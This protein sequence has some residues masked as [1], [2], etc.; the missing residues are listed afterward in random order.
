MRFYSK[1]SVWPAIFWLALPI[2]WLPTSTAAK[3]TV[4]LLVKPFIENNTI[5]LGGA[6]TQVT[7]TARVNLEGVAYHWTLSGPGTY[8]VDATSRKFYYTLPEHLS[9]A[10]AE[11]TIAVAVSEE[12]GETATEQ[13]TFS[14]HDPSPL[15]TAIPTPVP[16]QEGMT[17]PTPTA[18]LPPPKDLAQ[19]LEEAEAYFKRTFYTEPEGR[20]ALSLYQEVL[21]L[22]PGNQEARQKIREMAANLKQWAEKASNEADYGKAQR[23]LQRYGLIAQYLLTVPGEQGVKE[24]AEA[25][26]QRLKEL[27]SLVEEPTFSPTPTATPPPTPTVSQADSGSLETPPPTPQEMTPTPAP[28]GPANVLKRPGEAYAVIIGLGTYADA[29]IPPLRFTEND[30]QGL[31]DVLTDPRYGGIPQDHVKLLLDQAATEQAMKHAIGQ[32]L[33]QQA[34]EKDLVLLYFA[35]HT[36]DEDGDSFWV[37][38][39]AESDDFYATALNRADLADLFARIPAK[40]ILTFVDA[41][42]PAAGENAK[43]KTPPPSWGETLAGEGRITISAADG[44]Q[45]SLELAPQQHGLFAYYL[46]EGLKGEADANQDGLIDLTEL[47]NYL[48][49]QA[50]AASSKSG[51]PQTPQLQG[52]LSAIPLTA[53]PVILQKQQEEKQSQAKQ[54]RLIEIYR[55]GG[56]SAE[57]FTKAMAILKNKGRDQLLEDLLA[58]KLSLELFKESF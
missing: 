26:R 35:G 37:P 50:A 39:D 11:V 52:A 47:W 34:Q 20:N 4:Q 24:E 30:A 22:E 5:R 58:G 51:D 29:R 19:L 44:Q 16:S 2:L 15:P 36:A 1:R 41:S 7:I 3:P 21:R 32:W 13:V 38:H 17:T 46:L 42:Y 45:H 54:A 33:R 8:T 31:A 28:V 12:Q 9:A 53:N 43:E 23:Y 10:R 18:V 40:Q 55:T 6:V 48:Q 27:E 56:I 57:Q 14:L 25:V 49:A